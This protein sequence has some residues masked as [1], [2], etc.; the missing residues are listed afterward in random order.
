MARAD[1]I[2][3]S[4]ASASTLPRARLAGARGGHRA[5]LRVARLERWAA[6]R[7]T[8]AT[9]SHW[10]VLLSSISAAC[11]AVLL[12]TGAFLMLYYEPSSDPVVYDGS[13]QQ[14]RGREMTQAFATTLHMSLDVP[15]GLLVRQAHHWAALVLPAS[16]TLQLLSTYFSGGF[17]RPR[18]WSWVLL[19][20]LFVVVLIGGWSGYAL[21]DDLLSGTGLRIVQ[22]IMLSI[23]LVGAPLTWMFFGGEFPGQVITHLYWLHVLVVPLLLVPILVAR[24]RLARNL[25]PAQY[26]GPGRTERNLVGPPASTTAARALGLFFMSAGTLFI[27]GGTLTVAPVWLY[28][29]A[30]SSDASSGSQPDWY[31]GF[32]DGALRLVPPGWEVDWL[33]GTWPLAML[34]PQAVA[35]TFIGV[36][37]AYPFL[38]SA[39]TGDV[40]EHHLLDRPRNAPNRTGLGVAGLVFYGSMWA[41]GSTDMVTTHFHVA[42]ETQ[43]Y[44]LWFTLTAGPLIAFWITRLICFGLQARDIEQAHEGVET[45]RL[46]REPDGRYV[47]IHRPLRNGVPGPVTVRQPAAQHSASQQQATGHRATGPADTN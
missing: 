39:L 22:G 2:A 9:P 8:R 7:R 17:R 21:P 3:S 43:V 18:H 5:E 33:G 10:T 20:L 16:L 36:V 4:P 47:E 23:P 34:I 41:A 38:E 14:L 40:R 19:S 1:R 42:F 15:G 25:R 6:Q 37:V 12:L 27:M 13:Y 11:L 24:W 32:L 28:G 26:P 30:S 31:T 46:V 29:P 45:G 35:A 44:T